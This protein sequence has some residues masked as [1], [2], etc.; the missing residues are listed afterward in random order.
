MLCV[1][2]WRAHAADSN[3]V[4][5]VP[6]A[7][8]IRHSCEQFIAALSKHDLDAL[9]ALFAPDAVVN[10]PVDSPALVGVEK[11]RE[12]F[13]Q[14]IGLVRAA[15]LSGA[16]HVSR[17]CRHA[18]YSLEAVADFGDGLK[19]IEGVNVWTFDG[20]GRIATMKAYWDP[21]NSREA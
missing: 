4:A 18:A 3:R 8:D 10:D 14:G 15:S 16:V 9:V 11:I 2:C 1:V 6:T 13:A 17:D 5:R 12:F 21:D 19:V 20:E 7:D